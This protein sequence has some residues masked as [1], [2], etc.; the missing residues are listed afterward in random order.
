MGQS[1]LEIWQRGKSISVDIGEIP[2]DN[3]QWK[4]STKSWQIESPIEGWH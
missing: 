3:C 1:Q 4:S 2:T